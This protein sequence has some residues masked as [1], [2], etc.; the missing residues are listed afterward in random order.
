[1]ADEMPDRAAGHASGASGGEVQRLLRRGI[2][3][4]RFIG[5]PPQAFSLHDSVPP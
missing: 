2:S 4:R 3:P 5:P 1:M